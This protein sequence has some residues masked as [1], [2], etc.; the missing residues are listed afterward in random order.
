MTEIELTNVITTRRDSLM[1][2]YTSLFNS[3]CSARSLYLLLLLLAVGTAIR[4]YKL[5]YSGLWLDEI[6]SMEEAD[7]GTSLATVYDSIKKDQPPVYFFAL[8]AYLKWFG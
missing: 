7:P 5:D 8:H 6:F 4:F 2:R 1:R 3:S